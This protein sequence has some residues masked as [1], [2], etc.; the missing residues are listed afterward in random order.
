MA[1]VQAIASNTGASN[2][3]M[4]LT[5]PSG[6]ATVGNTIIVAVWTSAASMPNA[7]TDN[8]TPANTY[9]LV[10]TQS[11]NCFLYTAPVTNACT[12]VT[13]PA[14]TT[15]FRSAFV[16]EESGI[17]S[18]SPVDASAYNNSGGGTSWSSSSV[19]LTVANDTCYAFQKIGNTTTTNTPTS[20]MAQLTGTNITN[21]KNT[22]ST[23]G[24][25]FFGSRGVFTGTGSTTA[26]GTLSGSNTAQQG[27]V[28]LKPL[29]GPI[30]TVT[31][32]SPNPVFDGELGVII[33]GTNFG[34]S[35]GSGKIYLSPTDNVNNA[36]RVEQLSQSWSDTNINFHVIRGNLNYNATLY[37][38]VLNDTGQSNASGY[39]VS[40]YPIAQ[41]LGGHPRFQM[42]YR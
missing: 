15:G 13:V 39:P 18:S 6:A 29:A 8:A 4:N 19:N 32:V 28:W 3:A 12:I 22:N 41:P 34:A 38:F 31:L 24:Y 40:I 35:Q 33:A 20:P 37:L 1:L 27:F 7:P 17:T 26:Q 21:G 23:S 14:Q 16:C 42:H 36:S 30:P 2:T 5:L 9:T 11:G 10:A 25:D